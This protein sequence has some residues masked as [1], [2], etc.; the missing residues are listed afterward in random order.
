MSLRY[1]AYT[2]QFN[3]GGASSGG[4]GSL[5]PGAS[6]LGITLASGVFSIT[7][8]DGTAL[9]SSNPAY[10]VMPSST[11]GLTQQ[12]QITAD[13]SFEDASGTSDIT[14]NLFGLTAGV[15]ESNDVPF[16]IYAVSD[17]TDSTV[18]FGISRIPNIDTTSSAANLGSPSSATADVQA[19]I[20]FFNSV[21]LAN[22]ASRPCLCIGS[23]RMTKDTSNDWTVSSLAN[24][25]GIGNF[26]EGTVFTMGP[27]H[28]GNNSGKYFGL[29]GG[30]TF[31]SNTSNYSLTKD[32]WFQMSYLYVT[33]DS[34]GTGGSVANSYIPFITPVE[35]NLALQYNSGGTTN[36]LGN[37]KITADTQ[38]VK[39]IVPSVVANNPIKNS[40]IGTGDQFK[41]S[42]SYLIKNTA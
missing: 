13:Q 22:Y 37:T 33:C 11:E 20:F 2:G 38:G 4:G 7:G 41:V 1:N 24:S 34:A 9:S 14:G 27:G 40:D 5:T 6:N 28:Y 15:A 21:T 3:I 39:Y 19:S 42:V 23:F 17:S 25:D 32:G 31:S 12:F 30:P 26:N 18:S 35:V 36:V 16:Y 10:I 8:A 29:S